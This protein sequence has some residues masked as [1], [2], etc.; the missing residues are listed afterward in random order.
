MSRRITTTA[1]FV[2]NNLVIHHKSRFVA[3]CANFKGTIRITAEKETRSLAQNSLIRAWAQIIGN[4]LGM[5]PAEAHEM[6][7]AR[8]NTIKRSW[9][10]KKTGLIVDESFPG[11]THILSKD[12]MT[13]V[14][15]RYLCEAATMGIWLPA[16]ED[17]W[18]AFEARGRKQQ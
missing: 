5:D 4:E 13:E 16:S 14:M 1:H 12:A 10:N 18:M 7:K 3:G 17:E 2:D 9:V 15:E 6:M 8:V 11:P